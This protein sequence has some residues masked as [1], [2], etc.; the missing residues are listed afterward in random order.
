MSFNIG[1]TLLSWLEKKKPALYS[2]I[3][4]ADQQSMKRFSGHG[5]AIAQVYNHIIMP[6]ASRRDKETEIIW[7]IEDFVSRFNRRP[8]GMWLPETAVDIESLDIM[9]E[10]GILYTILSPVQARR[11]KKPGSDW[12]EAISGKFPIDLPYLCMLPSGR[13]ITIFFYD[14]AI[15]SEIA[16]GTLLENGELFAERIL[17]AFPEDNSYPRLISIATDGETYGHHHRFADMALAYA[18]H[19][20]ESSNLV[21]VT[22]YGEFLEKYPPKGEV[23]LREKS[24]WSCSHE[25]GRWYCDCGCRTYHACL[26]TDPLVTISPEITAPPYNPREWNQKWRTPLRE[27]MDYLNNILSVL[28]QKEG[29]ILFKNAD[30]ARNRYISLIRDRSEENRARFFHDVQAHTFIRDEWIHALRLLEMERNALLMYTSCGWFFDELAGIETVQVL[31]YACRAMQL[32]REVSGEDY[33]PVFLRC[34][35]QARSNI[36]DAG[37]GAE[38]YEKYVQTAIVDVS[39]VAFHYAITSLIEQ[40]PKETT[41]YTYSVRCESYRQGEA[42]IIRLATG[43]A[44]FRSNLTLDESNLVFAAIHIGDHNFMGGTS[45]YVS[46]SVYSQMQEE[47]WDAFHRSDIPGMIVSLSRYF[48]S[49]S[50]SLWDLFRDGRKRV[51]YS[52]LEDTL[53]DVESEYRQIFSRHFP[54][55]RAMN[56]MHIRPPEALEY[57]A[58]YILQHDIMNT[59]LSRKTDLHHLR[60]SVEELVHGRYSP[61]LPAFNRTAGEG[62]YRRLRDLAE[63]PED[64]SRIQELNEIFSL[65]KSLSLTPD[66]RDSQDLFFSLKTDLMDIMKRKADLGDETAREWLSAFRDLGFNLGVLSIPPR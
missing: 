35:R 50:Y 30:T 5:S 39:R 2:R 53:A 7:G 15:A 17:S 24:S 3:L 23:E 4:L 9:A 64:T 18:L 26:I 56:E 31:M 46:E 57:P 63:D 33:E 40:Y 13:T 8:E 49:H 60:M 32:A 48:E 6:L 52:V 20:L 36:P 51:L 41:L 19:A 34:I 44:F 62:I 29:A 45:T 16:F 14:S 10:Q 55:I 61:D 47:L 27:A 22:V 58:K 25:V 59:I 38:I 1:P 11:I 28:Y 42:G 21:N 12:I 66:F 37:S 65:L 43:H 54:L